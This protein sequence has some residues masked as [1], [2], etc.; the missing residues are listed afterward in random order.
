MPLEPSA[1]PIRFDEVITGRLRR[2]RAQ[3]YAWQTSASGLAAVWATRQHARSAVGRDGAQGG[4]RDDRHAAAVR[5]FGGFDFTADDLDRSDFAKY[6][7]DKACRWAAIS[8]PRPRA[9][10]PTLLI[11][12]L[13]DVDGANLDRIQVI[14]GWLDAN[15]E[16]HEQ[17]Y[18]VAWSGDRKPGADGKLPPVG[19]TVNVEEASYTNTIG[20]PFLQ[21]YLEGPGLRPEASAPSTTC[22]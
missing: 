2:R 3:L 7:Y 22:A 15:G 18:D 6:G 14:K 9:R 4:V 1:D 19:N 13:R 21:A 16:T 12:A 5:V 11:R 20:A 10:R 17:V 8:P